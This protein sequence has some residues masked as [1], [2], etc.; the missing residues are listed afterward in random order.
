MVLLYWRPNAGGVAIRTINAVSTANRSGPSSGRP[1]SSHQPVAKPTALE[2]DL[3]D[4]RVLREW[5]EKKASR[6]YVR[7]QGGGFM[8]VERARL[9]N[10]PRA[11]ETWYTHDEMMAIKNGALNATSVDTTQ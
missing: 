1:A 9:R 2:I 6:R 11:G 3:N 10:E 5:E 7:T 8:V 4:Q